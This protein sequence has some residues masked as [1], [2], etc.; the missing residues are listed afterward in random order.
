MMKCKKC[1]GPIVAELLDA[2]RCDELIGFPNVTLINS[3]TQ[4]K[5]GVCGA[6]VGIK[7]PDSEGLEAALAMARIARPAR[8]TGKE[9]RFLRG[10][11][12]LL[13]KDFAANLEVRDETVSRWENDRE[14]IGPHFDKLIRCLVFLLVGDKAPGIVVDRHALASMRVRH[15]TS[16][17]PMSFVFERVKVRVADRRETEWELQEKGQAAA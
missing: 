6:A 14:E 2:Y 13:A 4:Y 3:A 12:G 8:L 9:V 17:E 1:D 10:T 15:L 5:C 11:C 16:T 7:I